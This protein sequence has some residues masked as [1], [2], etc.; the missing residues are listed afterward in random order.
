MVYPIVFF[1]RPT[2]Y[3]SFHGQKTSTITQHD[4][5]TRIFRFV[6]H[7][8]IFRRRIW[9]WSS[10]HETNL[11]VFLASISDNVHRTLH[12][13]LP[14][15]RFFFSSFCVKLIPSFTSR[16]IP[17]H[18]QWSWPSAL[19][20]EAIARCASIWFNPQ[21]LV[22]CHLKVT[23]L[24]CIPLFWSG[25]FYIPGHTWLLCIY[26]LFF[27]HSSFRRWAAS[28]SC[29][30]PIW[31]NRQLLVDCHHKA[32]ILFCIPLFWSG[33]FYIPEHTWLHFKYDL[34]LNTLLLVV[35]LHRIHLN[36][37]CKPWKH[38]DFVSNRRISI[39]Q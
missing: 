13:L 5:R 3:R 31:S 16:C 19:H 29:W 20:I 4:E 24:L 7:H 6:S 39:C 15:T 8:R 12:V 9:T 35:G 25:F 10:Y 23:I 18:S 1:P 30:A 37:G 34:V 27:E 32:T 26:E 2:P 17:F 14:V 38:L 21:R 36:N 22:D 28:D 33:F 11:S